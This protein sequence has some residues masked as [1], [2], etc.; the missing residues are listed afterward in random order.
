MNKQILWATLACL[1]M[2]GCGGEEDTGDRV[3]AILD[4]EGDPA[5]G[6]GVYASE[7]ASCHGAD[8]EGG[9]GPAMEDALHHGDAETVEVILDGIGGMPAHDYLDDQEIADVL[10]YITQEW[11]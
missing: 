1:G 3:A 9:S 11:G 8:G 7:C 6:E 2:M 10:A 5:A 4:L